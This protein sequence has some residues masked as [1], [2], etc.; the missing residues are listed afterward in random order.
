MRWIVP[1]TQPGAAEAAARLCRELKLA[2][3]VARLLTIRGFS[4]PEAAERFLRPRLDH[5]HDPLLM[6]DMSAAV[7]RLRQAIAQQE[8][9]LI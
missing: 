4:D 3:L 2:P 5:L 8:K 9:I 6:A 1:N 7:T